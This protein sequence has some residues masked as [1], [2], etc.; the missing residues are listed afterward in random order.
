M[1][2]FD[3]ALLKELQASTSVSTEVLGGNVGLSASACQRRIKKMKARGLIQKEV[4]ILD[5]GKFPRLT[6][7]I[8]EVVL[9]SGGEKALDDIIDR[10]TR[11][12]HVQQLYYTSGDVDF[13]AIF[14]VDGMSQFDELSRRLLMAD[15]NIKKFHSRVVIQSNKVTSA[16][17]L[18][19]Y[20]PAGPK[21][22]PYLT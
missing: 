3:L 18:D 8:V 16:L 5:S 17:P 19:S 6:T 7:V 12:D 15:P 22:D 11:E 10:F 14:I 21:S 4:A 2:K 1:D 13:V 20:R 9:D